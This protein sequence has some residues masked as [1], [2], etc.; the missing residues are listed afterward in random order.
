MLMW[1]TSGPSTSSAPPLHNQSSLAEARFGGR[2]PLTSAHGS[3]RLR[4][5]D[6]LDLGEPINFSGTSRSHTK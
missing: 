2:A 6:D 5:L 3:Y 4:R 1:M